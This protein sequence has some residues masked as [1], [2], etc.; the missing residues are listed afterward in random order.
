MTK[1][2]CCAI[3]RFAIPARLGLL[4]LV[5]LSSACIA[6]G[7]EDVYTI[8]YHGSR[9]ELRPGTDADTYWKNCALEQPSAHPA[10]ADPELR[11]P[12]CMKLLLVWGEALARDGAD[13]SDADRARQTNRV[14]PEQVEH[15]RG[16]AFV[17]RAFELL[18]S[19]L[20][21]LSGAALDRRLEIHRQ[22]DLQVNWAGVGVFFKNLAPVHAAAAN[23]YLT[24]WSLLVNPPSTFR[25]FQF[26]FETAERLKTIFHDIVFNNELREFNGIMPAALN[27]F[28][29]AYAFHHAPPPDPGDPS[30]PKFVEALLHD[31]VNI[32]GAGYGVYPGERKLQPL[33]PLIRTDLEL[34][35]QV[36][37]AAAAAKL[38]TPADLDP[39][40]KSA[41]TAIA[42]LK[43]GELR[44]W[45]DRWHKRNDR[46]A[47]AETREQLVKIYA[48]QKDLATAEREEKQVCALLLETGDRKEWSTQMMVL[49]TIRVAAKEWAEVLRMLPPVQDKLLDFSDFETL[50]TSMQYQASAWQALNRKADIDWDAKLRPWSGDVK[51]LSS[52]NL[53]APD[54]AAANQLA[55]WL[56]EPGHLPSNRFPVRMA[57]SRALTAQRRFQ[58]A[59][60]VTKEA[61]A[62]ADR[63]EGK[64]IK[65]DL[66]ERLLTIESARGSLGEFYSTLEQYERVGRE[67]HGENWLQ[68]DGIPIAQVLYRIRDFPK[69]QALVEAE[70]EREQWKVLRDPRMLRSVDTALQQNQ[71]LRAR[72]DL[73]RGRKS[74]AEKRIAGLDQYAA[75]LKSRPVT[76]ED[77]RDAKLQ[78]LQQLA[79]MSMALGRHEKALAYAQQLLAATDPLKQTDRWVS[80]KIAEARALMALNRDASEHIARFQELA[81]HFTEYKDLGA[82]HAVDMEIVVAD[83]YAGKHDTARSVEWLTRALELANQLGAIDQ[84]VEIHRKL[85]DNAL[86]Q[87]DPPHAIEEFRRSISL[88]SS[89]SKS[90]PSDL[91]KVGYRGERSTAISRLV[92][93]LYDQYRATGAKQHVEEMFQAVEEG[94]ARAL[95]EMMFGSTSTALPNFGVPAVQRALPPDGLLLEY[96]I[97]DD[98]RDAVFRFQIGRDTIAVAALPIRAS[99]LKRRVQA[100]LDDATSSPDSYDDAAFRRNAADLGRILLPENLG[101]PGNHQLLIAPAGSLYLFPFSLLANEKGRFIDED[102]E[103]SLSYLP[104][105]AFLLQPAPLLSELK[106]AAGFGNPAGEPEQ[107]STARKPELRAALEQAFHKWSGGTIAWEQPLTPQQFLDRVSQADN[108]FLYSHAT[109]LPDDPISSYIKLS[110]D[111]GDDGHLSAERLLAQKIGHGLWVLAA[112]STGS[113]DVESGDEVLGLPRALL[114]AGASSVIVSLWEVDQ[115]LSMQLMTALYNNLA[116]GMTLSAALHSAANDLRRAGRPPFDWAPFILTGHYGFRN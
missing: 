83:Y 92:V 104:N 11:G 47:E 111:S 33:F 21:R 100:H 27:F 36:L 96:Y 88:L 84:Q 75:D 61:L 67:L 116:T 38:M 55:E 71:M 74:S 112:C 50:R 22:L 30:A 54:T 51:S 106:R 68:T 14:E 1:S 20:D 114:Q 90:I 45:I 97:P 57:L 12:G 76:L 113:G 6:A 52:L 107:A 108:L 72:I 37:N 2:C 62:D 23:Y 115:V 13:I 28:D 110:V 70:E 87:N 105:A 69:S 91:G 44:S 109:F 16:K 43:V 103:L 81:P 101:G 53:N 89:V 42:A 15:E 93:T 17:Q 94:K 98:P 60:A 65:Q 49:A 19:D 29:D 58:E 66:L 80:V 9:D 25:A 18:R 39:R 24:V 35:L 86:A 85:G 56:K 79:E 40:I 102:D 4:T 10:P 34:A 63:F 8:T 64:S 73:E 32:E 7:A 82:E 77:E 31:E 5:I 48:E 99:E 59:E 26:K 78:L 46:V 3:A 41:Q 95:A